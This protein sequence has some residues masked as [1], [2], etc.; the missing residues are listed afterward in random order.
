MILM[1][2]LKKYRTDLIIKSYIIIILLSVI[3]SC[4]DNTEHKRLM[5]LITL[6]TTRAE[7]INFKPK[8]VQ[9]PNL[10]YLVS[11][12]VAFK[13]AYSHIPITLP[14]HLSMLYSM[15]PWMLGV[16]NN[17][18]I[19]NLKYPSLAEILKRKGYFTGAVISLGVLK[20]DFGLNKGF[21][22]FN[23]DFK[24]GLWYRTAEDVNNS[25]FKIIKKVKRKKAFYWVHYSDPHDPYYPPKYKGSFSIEMNGKKVYETES[26]K[27]LTVSVKIKL[28]K[29]LNRLNFKV[30]LPETFSDELKKNISGIG[31][32]GFKI[33]EI[34]NVENF[35]IKMNPDW[36]K[37]IVKGRTDFVT[38]NLNSDIFITNKTG[39][40]KNVSL[41]FVYELRLFNSYKKIM[42]NEEIKYMDGQIG[43]L[44]SFLKER[45]LFEN[46]TFV[47]MGDHGEGLGE[48]KKHYGHI[49]YL[50]KV[51]LNVPLIISGKGVKK[52]IS[53]SHLV[54][55]LN[56]APTILD[57]AKLKIPKYMIGK[58]LFN[59]NKNNN[60]FFET[61]RPQAYLNSFSIV[62]YP[63]QIVYFPE[64]SGVEK[65]EFYNIKDDRFGVNKIEINSVEML[66]MKNKI[67]KMAR[68]CLKN[69]DKSKK[70]KITKKNED[71]LKSLGY[72]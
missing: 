24:D 54:S 35:T 46:T 14:S 40:E 52:D 23:E 42:Y 11:R 64:K 43:K 65:F 28:K 27:S 22:I 37:R 48:Y 17:G 3:F 39:R 33:F 50:N 16:Y 38:S 2:Y 71:I 53:T 1:R 55:T 49:H 66:K 32:R 41:N 45:N 36:I 29:G 8:N 59:K 9:T 15:P 26:I 18:D 5:F 6:D 62:D 67:V 44:I 58:S 57:I 69:K 25:L 4:S 56:I 70:K 63:Y 72:I 61:Y 20:S 34:D 12:G 10:A 47:I 31:F 21:N 13:N 60:I 7:A 68:L 30:E 51:Y 19:K